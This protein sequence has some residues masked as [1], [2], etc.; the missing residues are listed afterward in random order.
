MSKS[1]FSSRW[2]I[3]ILLLVI[4]GVALY[5]RVGPFYDSVFVGDNVKFTT[6][7]AYYF[8]R[9][10]D[11]LANHYPHLS[12]IDPY[13]NYPTSL[14]LGSTNFFIFLLS[15]IAWIF[16]MG[17]PSTHMLNVVSAYLPAILGALTVIPV[18]FIGKALFN[19]GVGIVAAALIAFLPGELLGRTFLGVADRDALEILLTTLTM[20]FLIL[21]VKSAREKQ[22]TF[23]QLVSHDLPI[24][25]KPIIYSLLSGILL[26]LSILTWRGSFLF[27]VVFLV[28]LVIQSIIDYVKNK[29]FAGIS[30]VGIVTFLAALMIVGIVTQSQLLSV[31]LTISLFIPMVLLG[32][33]WL[34]RRWKAN[35]FFYFLSIVGVAGICIGIF[36][37][38]SPSLFKSITEQFSVLI[39]TGTLSTVTEM[40]SI[41]FPAGY[42]TLDIIW[43]NYSTCFFFSIIALVMLIYFFFKQNRGENLFIILWSLIMLVATLDLRRFAP[44]FAITVALL[45]GYLAIILY[46]AFQFVINKLMSKSNSHVSSRLLEFIGLKAPTAVSPLAEVSPQ[47]E[48]LELDYYQILGIPRNASHKQ[49]KKAHAR[50]A[51]RSQISGGST[52][53][54]KEKLKQIDRAYSVLS[55]Q[56]KRADYDHSQYYNAVAQGKDKTK[57]SKRGGFQATKL[58]NVAVAGL[59]VFFLAFF[60]NFKPATV[61]AD[62]A[63]SLIP[64][65]AWYSSLAWLKDNTPE[66]FGS[67]TFYYDLY[68]TPFNYPETAYGVAAWWDYGYMVLNLGHRIPNCDPGGGS[69]DLVARLFTA[70]NEPAA[71]EFANNL[72]SKYVIIDFSTITSMYGALA[73]YAGTSSDQFSDIYYVPANGGLR[74]VKYY[75]PQYYQ[76]LAVRLFIFSGEETTSKSTD[77]ISYMEKV[78]PDGY[79]YKEV[80]DTKT[81]TSYEEAVDYITE[82]DS[83]NYRIVSSDPLSSPIPLDKLEHYKL[84]YS[85]NQSSL[86]YMNQ[87][88]PTLTIFEYIR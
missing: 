63:K 27:V 81:F 13:L 35:S 18:Y 58:I 30:F 7:D 4:F 71:N 21:A 82:Q 17:S 33:S 69:R 16:G 5:I 80:T 67:D 86:I 87:T 46:Y 28:Y 3:I 34:L 72:N 2:L 22:L 84:V 52:D 31:A 41:L 14:P 62:Q 65:D 25:I 42:F 66:P 64:S 38:A 60:P 50:L 53:E 26:G 76:S 24:F 51:F 15:G 77:V 57:K 40:R 48:S 56:K 12:S 70:Q 49:I 29:S 44:F 75:Y 78:T 37:A 83:G 32:L 55:D 36:Y 39:P 11:N 23:R 20:L 45:T 9:Q 79:R 47:E 10:A 6:N 74:A 85:S 88:V 43:G 61:M 54:G 19:R 68:Q 59:A 8:V 73:T 1:K